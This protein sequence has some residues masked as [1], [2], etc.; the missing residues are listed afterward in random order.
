MHMQKI[1]K[2]PFLPVVLSTFLLFLFSSCSPQSNIPVEGLA[3]PAYLAE[4]GDVEPEIIDRAS[5]TCGDKE[6]MC[7]GVVI[8][9]G[10]INDQSINQFAWEGVER[11][12]YD[13]NAQVEY[14][15]TGTSLDYTSSI[16]HFAERKFDV[17]V[18]VGF[19]MRNATI[20][21]A[22][23]YPD[24]DFVGVD[25]NYNEDYTNIT[26]LVFP[27]TSIGFLAGALAA[28]VSQNK[29][30]GVILG[31]HASLSSGTFNQ[32]FR[33]GVAAIDGDIDIMSIHYPGKIDQSYNDPTWGAKTAQF[34]LDAGADVIV[35]TA[36]HTGDGAL[37]EIAKSSDAFCIGVDTD[38]WLVLPEAQSCLVSSAMKQI[39]N[40]VFELIAHS[41]L[42][43]M[44]Y[45]NYAGNAE[46]APF[47]QYD[48][49]F[50]ADVK[51]VLADLK[52]GLANSS[53]PTDGSYIVADPPT[54]VI[55]R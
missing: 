30:V 35:A 11:A 1:K 15:E 27:E 13:L 2:S 6:L 34:M 7:V 22:Q 55:E 37:V 28:M 25:Q 47:H 43:N 52:I 21:V 8:G 36:G 10:G 44:P 50:S 38:H 54:V 17:I 14:L 3:N 26:G 31:P 51:Q 42:G 46:L 53:I 4:V 41:L 32:G 12:K 20:K 40:G 23:A 16:E 19:S 29:V 33:S 45:G 48:E 24:I 49:F 9:A 39:S 5:L 18:T